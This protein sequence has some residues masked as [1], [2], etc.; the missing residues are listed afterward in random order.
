[1]NSKDIAAKKKVENVAFEAIEP[2]NMK[3]VMQAIELATYEISSHIISLKIN[4]IF[5]YVNLLCTTC[6]VIVTSL[7][8]LTFRQREEI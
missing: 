7:E 2:G 8:H 5:L 4:A 3:F 6:D 1:M